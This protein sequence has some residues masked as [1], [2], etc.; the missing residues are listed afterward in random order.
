MNV[1][2]NAV[3]DQVAH[4][5]DGWAV[6]ECVARHQDPVASRGELGQLV[7]ILQA[8][9]QRLLDEHVLAGFQ[10]PRARA[11]WVCGGVAITTASIAGSTQYCVQLSDRLGVA[12][13]PAEVLPAATCRCRTMAPSA[14]LGIRLRCERG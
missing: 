12:V 3:A 1:A 8:C 4:R 14:A 11:W 6:N 5:V 9:G 7:G 13:T 10:C 2:D